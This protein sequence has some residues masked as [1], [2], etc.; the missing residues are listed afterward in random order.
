MKTINCKNL[1]TNLFNN[2][3]YLKDI[4]LSQ[5]KNLLYE[6][7]IAK[8]IYFKYFAVSKRRKLFVFII[9]RTEVS[10]GQAGVAI[11][12]PLLPK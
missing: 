2:E 10:I 4:I 11:L 6:E 1:S 3:F 12:C 8:L 9:Y 7:H 5:K